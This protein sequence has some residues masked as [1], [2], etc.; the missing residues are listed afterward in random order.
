MAY[1]FYQKLPG[2]SLRMITFNHMARVFWAVK[3]LTGRFRKV[4]PLTNK[5]EEM[6]YNACL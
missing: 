4:V 6:T 5:E 1:L 2:P 3:M